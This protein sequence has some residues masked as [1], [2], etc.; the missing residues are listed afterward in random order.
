MNNN[1]P[2]KEYKYKLNAEDF[3]KLFLAN[4]DEFEELKLQLLGTTES[5]IK[6][7][8]RSTKLVNTEIAGEV[9]I[10]G[11]RMKN[12]SHLSCENVQFESFAIKYS[13]L[14]KGKIRTRFDFNKCVIGDLIISKSVIGD[15]S[16]NDCLVNDVDIYIADIKS[17][18]IHESVTG[19]FRIWNNSKIEDFYIYQSV[20]GSFII[21]DSKTRNF[22]I[23]YSSVDDF[24]ISKSSISSIRIND[25]CT[26]YISTNDD[27][28]IENIS[29]HSSMSGDFKIEDTRMNSFSAY[30]TCC[31]F[32]ILNSTISQ[33]RTLLCEIPE[34]TIGPNCKIEVYVT[35]GQINEVN[36][37]NTS[38]NKDSLISF[39]KTAIY[40]LQME[41][42]SML[43][44]LYLRQ[45]I[46]TEKLFDWIG[47]EE[48]LKLLKLKLPDNSKIIEKINKQHTINQKEY[49]KKCNLL[50]QKHNKPTIRISQSSL[51][52][53]EF[54]N[55][56]LADYRFEFNSSKI[57]DCFISGG[58]IPKENIQIIN[59]VQNSIEEYQQKASFFNQFK[60][61]FESQGD[62]YHATQFQ[63]KWA[64]EQRNL[65]ELIHKKEKG[66]FNTTF[67]DLWIL[68]LNKWSNLH[69]E[70]W[71]RAFIWIMS[72]GLVFYLPY[73]FSI[74]RLFTPSK[75]DFNLI[76]YYFEFLNPAHRF[77]FINEGNI[78]NGLTVFIDLVWRI[79][80]AYLI[81]QFI[82]AFR[83]HTKK[84]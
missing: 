53:A 84:Q 25:S 23:N 27:T 5:N 80:V 10:H 54:T 49:E 28:S 83:K 37:H 61:I 40:C 1:S 79:V 69:G 66:W 38:L 67:S 11:K 3:E 62:I 58:S 41:E 63:A 15:I 33:F 43:G 17:I 65:L 57:T 12:C 72:L 77:N 51:G 75:F 44:N 81:F 48:F 76:G 82:V 30:L 35:N 21:D 34:F 60:K 31:S 16:L 18:F 56:P 26:G 22:S 32:S 55:C 19:N 39:S 45:I 29:V 7:E 59:T 50:L 42:F 64:D 24:D 47:L 4:D 73:L 78:A 14:H 8:D 2:S 9:I 68:K 74:G 70:S 52:K 20:L 71:P 36:F 46:L 13:S 6:R